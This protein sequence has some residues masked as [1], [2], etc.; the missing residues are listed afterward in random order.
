MLGTADDPL[1]TADFGDEVDQHV[2]FPGG[3]GLAVSWHNHDGVQLG[4][5]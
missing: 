2:P 3:T 4:Q 5:V 1:V